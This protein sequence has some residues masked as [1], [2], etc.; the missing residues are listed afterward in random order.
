MHLRSSGG[1]CTCAFGLRPS[2]QYAKS[3]MYQPP[4]QGGNHQ[5]GDCYCRGYQACCKAFGKDSAKKADFSEIVIAN[6]A[7]KLAK[8]TTRKNQ[9]AAEIT[10]LRDQHA[11]L[12]AAIVLAAPKA[13][14]PVKKAAKSA[15][16]GSSPARLARLWQRS[17]MRQSAATST[18]RLTSGVMSPYSPNLVMPCTWSCSIRASRASAPTP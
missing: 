12:K 17:L 7:E 14:V 9:I 4:S 1:W 2:R 15:A 16:T 6:I 3:E 11:A 8:L 13:V 18:R 5:I 10:T